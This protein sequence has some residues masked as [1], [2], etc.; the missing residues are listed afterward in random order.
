MTV[1]GQRIRQTQGERREEAERRILEATIRLVSQHGFANLTMSEVGEEAGYSRGLPGH[2]YGSKDN[3]ML[4]VA[5]HILDQ[6]QGYSLHHS[7]VTKP[8]L[9]EVLRTYAYA[10]RRN[11]DFARATVMIY[12][13]ALINKPFSDRLRPIIRERIDAIADLLAHELG[14][15]KRR[16]AKDL[17]IEAAKIFALLRG[18]LNLS[19]IDPE[20]PLEPV[21]DAYAAALRERWFGESEAGSGEIVPRAKRRASA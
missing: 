6:F 4:A 13:E 9:D 11:P 3:L 12:S 15:K 19:A 7:D 17:K 10:V 5:T 20:F 1:T 14:E 2:Y 21:L 8:A 16:P 18:A